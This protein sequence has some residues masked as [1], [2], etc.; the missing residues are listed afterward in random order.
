MNKITDLVGGIP[1]KLPPFR[2]VN[3]EIKLIDPGKQIIYCLPKCPNTLKAELAEKIS[4]YTSPGW[5][6]PTTAQQ[7]VPMLCVLKKSGKLCTVFDLRMQNDNTKKDVSP[8][9]DQDMIRHD[10]ACAPYRS[11]LDMSEAYE[12]IHIKLEDVPKTTFSTIFGTFVS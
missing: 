2:E 1:T 5:W 11:K 12:Q 8:F 9:P 3:H 7:A 10:I 6:V 4:R